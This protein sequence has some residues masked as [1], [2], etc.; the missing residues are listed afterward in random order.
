M[1]E[2]LKEKILETINKYI[3]AVESDNYI[4]SLYELGVLDDVLII[5]SDPFYDGDCL[6]VMSKLLKRLKEDIER[7]LGHL[8]HKY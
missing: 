3:K 1:S 6:V 5:C 4:I 8:N 2:K 7:I